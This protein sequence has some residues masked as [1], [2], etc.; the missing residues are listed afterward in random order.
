MKP[1]APFALLAC[2]ATFSAACTS[3]T[4]ATSVKATSAVTA[5]GPASAQVA[6]VKGNSSL[7]FV[8]N[9]VKAKVGVLTLTLGNIGGTPHNLT[10]DEPSFPKIDIVSAGPTKSATLQL[11]KPGVYRFVCTIHSGMAGKLV[12][13]A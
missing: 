10:F 6:E 8:P 11:T 12:V 4:G 1:A 3:N 7:A 2:L 9:T 5:T 13:T